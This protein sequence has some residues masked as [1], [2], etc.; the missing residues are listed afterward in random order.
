MAIQSVITDTIANLKRTTISNKSPL[1]LP[2]KLPSHKQELVVEDMSHRAHLPRTAGLA[3]LEA[4]QE[5]QNVLELEYTRNSSLRD[6][7]ELG[8]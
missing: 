5:N 3:N 4:E 7:I 2:L 1:L 8:F 6:W